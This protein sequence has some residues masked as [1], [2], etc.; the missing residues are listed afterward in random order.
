ME[1]PKKQSCSCFGFFSNKSNKKVDKGTDAEVIGRSSL[2]N[3]PGSFIPTD[4]NPFMNNSMGSTQKLVSKFPLSNTMTTSLCKTPLIY[5]LTS[6]FA[7]NR[8][9]SIKN[10][11]GTG[12]NFNHQPSV[13]RRSSMPEFILEMNSCENYEELK[14]IQPEEKKLQIYEN[15][16]L[17]YKTDI[18]PRNK[19]SDALKKEIIQSTETSIIGNKDIGIINKPASQ[20]L[21]IILLGGKGREGEK[22]NEEGKKIV[23]GKVEE[24]KKIEWNTVKF[25]SDK[26]N[27]EKK[28]RN[29]MDE[30]KDQ[31]R[32]MVITED[33]LELM[34]SPQSVSRK[35]MDLDEKTEKLGSVVEK[36]KEKSKTEPVETFVENIIK[37]A[38][39][40]FK[41]IEKDSD[42]DQKLQD[43]KAVNLQTQIKPSLTGLAS[44]QSLT[45]PGGDKTNKKPQASKSNPSLIRPR[46]PPKYM[47][48]PPSIPL[49]SPKAHIPH[50]LSNENHSKLRRSSSKSP[51]RSLFLKDK[52]FEAM[53]PV[54][55]TFKS[56]TDRDKTPILKDTAMKCFE[57]L[58]SNKQRT[59]DKPK[60]PILN[61]DILNTKPPI[62]LS[63]KSSEREGNKLK[64]KLLKSLEKS[65]STVVVHESVNG[66][67][68]SAIFN[69]DLNH[70][71]SEKHFTTLD[72]D[73]KSNPMISVDQVSPN[74][75]SPGYCFKRL[76][77]LKI[78]PIKSILS[79][80]DYSDIIS[81]LKNSP[82]ASKLSEKL[83]IPELPVK[84]Q[85]KNKLP[86]LKPITPHYFHK[87][88]SAPQIKNKAKISVENL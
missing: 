21:Q 1:R 11:E 87:K 27:D 62:R 19:S 39:F 12:S 54:Q 37:K 7:H 4:D 30:Q 26:Q 80:D 20:D 10:P 59:N 17:S 25:F 86:A 31:E 47:Q 74:I 76:P 43:S 22:V 29:K 63:Q 40:D 70:S 83:M 24:E 32:V 65:N 82:N 61:L 73:S 57:N 84:S 44:P 34:L 33:P 15:K 16:G 46:E 42:S 2:S 36:A 53:S 13:N 64:E 67:K 45:R 85:K 9:N 3:F 75:A 72:L 50:K 81:F 69:K 51:L 38:D 56:P 68:L 60:I 5:N 58:V 6:S 78:S 14:N 18:F 66:T 8:E 41:H 55:N 49:E 77:S 35:T 71:L 23:V 28:N 88:R 48:I 79:I 52:F